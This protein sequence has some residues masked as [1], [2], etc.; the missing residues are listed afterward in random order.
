MPETG[1]K[2]TVQSVSWIRNTDKLIPAGRMRSANYSEIWLIALKNIYILNYFTVGIDVVS[3]DGT[4][5][6]D[7]TPEPVKHDSEDKY[8][9]NSPEGV[10]PPGIVP[11]SGTNLKNNT[12]HTG[13][14]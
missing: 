4:K 5:D 12:Y 2:N 3:H 9:T 7:S 10:L 1:Y 8:S 14:Q 11:R 6:E 13:I